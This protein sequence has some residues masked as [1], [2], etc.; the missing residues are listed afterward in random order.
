MGRLQKHTD[1]VFKA[2]D[3]Q[4]DQGESAVQRGRPRQRYAVIDEVKALANG[5]DAKAIDAGI[6]ATRTKWRNLPFVEREKARDLDRKFD[7][8][9]VAAKK[10][11]TVLS[12]GSVIEAMKN[13]LAAITATEAAD[14]TRQRW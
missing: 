11:A 4:R 13:T 9:L 2:R 6:A 14:K 8:A 12:R 3:A 5:D 7:D 1:A 10:R